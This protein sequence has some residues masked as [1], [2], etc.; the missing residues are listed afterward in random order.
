MYRVWW[1]INDY[2]NIFLDPH[3]KTFN[4]RHNELLI[5]K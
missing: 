3:N 4:L 1:D 5:I 2:M